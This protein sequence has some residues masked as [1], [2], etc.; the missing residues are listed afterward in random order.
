MRINDLLKMAI[1]RNASDL[2]LKTGNYPVL[3]ING[4]L[5]LQHDLTIITPKDVDIFFNEVTTETQRETFARELEADFAY[6]AQD[7]GRFRINI[8]QQEGTVC[9]ACRPIKAEVPTMEDLGLP[10]I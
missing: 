9:L 1:T 10:E 6:H 5:I 4:E 3:R 8:S 2:H 7:V